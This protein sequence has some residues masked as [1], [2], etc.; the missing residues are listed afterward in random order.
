MAVG[1]K[2]TQNTL[3]VKGQINQ[4]LWSPR[5]AFFWAK[6]IG[7]DVFG[8]KLFSESGEASY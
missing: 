3:L 5:V 2:G 6:V 1:Q 4:N 8:G 7:V